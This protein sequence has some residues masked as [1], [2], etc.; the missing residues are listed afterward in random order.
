MLPLPAVATAARVVLAPLQI[1]LE[2]LATVRVGTILTVTFVMA[3]FVH[4]LAAVPMT[5]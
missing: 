3:E 2:A 5:E 4:P 1:V